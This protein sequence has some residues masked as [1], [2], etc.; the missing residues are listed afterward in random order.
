VAAAE[1]DTD[2]MAAAEIGIG[3]GLVVVGYRIV[4]HT[5]PHMAA[6]DAAVGEGNHIVD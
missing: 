6:V 1:I 4:A 2:P 5:V 3:T